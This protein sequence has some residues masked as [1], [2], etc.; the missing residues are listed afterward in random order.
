[1]SG[2]KQNSFKGVMGVIFNKKTLIIIILPQLQNCLGY[3]K[4]ISIDLKTH[5]YC[6][7]QDKITLCNW[8]KFSTKIIRNGTGTGDKLSKA[9]YLDQF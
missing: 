2:I 7:I 4:Y 6:A 9:N 3:T 8:C 1:M 5:F